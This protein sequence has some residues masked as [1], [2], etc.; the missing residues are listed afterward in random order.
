MGLDEAASH[1]TPIGHCSAQY[2]GEPYPKDL[3][4][5][6]EG[7]HPISNQSLQRALYEM[8]GYSY[9]SLRA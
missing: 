7:T 1:V 9:H 3:F 8:R 5:V 4:L 6:N 2:P